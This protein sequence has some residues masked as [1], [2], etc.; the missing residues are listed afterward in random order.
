MT[1]SAARWRVIAGA[2][3]GTAFK[4]ATPAKVLENHPDV[5]NFAFNQSVR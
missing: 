1:G 3:S 2:D 5:T 4:A